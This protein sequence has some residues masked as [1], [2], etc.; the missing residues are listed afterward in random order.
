MARSFFRTRKIS[1]RSVRFTACKRRQATYQ[2]G[3]FLV[4]T[5]KF[6]ADKQ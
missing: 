1:G 3:Q 5:S 6:A 4:S 2:Y